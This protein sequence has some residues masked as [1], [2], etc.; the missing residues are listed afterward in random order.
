L[1]SMETALY[2]PR[3]SLPEWSTGRCEAWKREYDAAAA[4]QLEENIRIARWNTSNTSRNEYSYPPQIAL[5][6]VAKGDG[7]EFCDPRDARRY[8]AQIEAM[9]AEIAAATEKHDEA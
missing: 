6:S 9:R 5:Q 7:W 3:L 8:S 1:R 2:L 4:G